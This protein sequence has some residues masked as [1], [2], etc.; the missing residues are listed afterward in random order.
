MKKNYF[1][2]LLVIATLGLGGCSFSKKSST[3]VNNKPIVNTSTSDTTATATLPKIEE[4]KPSSATLYPQLTAEGYLA[5]I[6]EDQAQASRA[7]LLYSGSELNET[8]KK[9]ID[10]A[11]L[12]INNNCNLQIDSSVTL[13]KDLLDKIQKGHICRYIKGSLGTGRV[14]EFTVKY[15]DSQPFEFGLSGSLEYNTAFGSLILQKQKPVN[16]I[17]EQTPIITV[18]G[19]AYFNSNLAP[20]ISTSDSSSVSSNTSVGK[21]PT[22]VSVT[23]T[24][25]SNA[26]IYLTIL[27]DN[28]KNGRAV[29]CGDSLVPVGVHIDFSSSNTETKAKEALQKLFSLRTRVYD[30]KLNIV[31]QLY[32]SVLSINRLTIEDGVATVDIQGTLTLEGMC[33]R[34]IVE[35]QIKQTIL[36]FKPITK[37]NLRI[38]TPG[39]EDLFN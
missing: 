24:V 32:N 4:T 38:N 16:L 12:D 22:N 25:A 11:V 13:N 28:G 36:Q 19:K 21:N 18:L 14:D 30:K 35:E 8:L 33:D 31:N 7:R 9:D 2:V 17:E 39:P 6:N 3:V 34:P 1:L 37:V 23:K 27:G 15:I 5:L 20:I 29:G 10:N 26:S